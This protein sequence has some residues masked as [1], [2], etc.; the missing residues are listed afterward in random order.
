MLKTKMSL[1]LCLVLL[2]GGTTLAFG[3]GWQRRPGD[4]DH[5]RDDGYYRQ[6]S[7]DQ[8]KYYNRGLQDGQ[9][10]ARHNLAFRMRDHDWRRDQLQAYASG[11]RA[12]FGSYRRGDGD[13]DRDDRRGYGYGQPGV[14][15]YGQPGQYGGYAS[16][17]NIGYQDGLRYGASDRNT[18]HSFRPTNSSAYHD[19]KRGSKKSRVAESSGFPDVPMT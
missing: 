19:A 8:Q 10:D 4:G 7:R 15:G 14:Y 5:D 1:A 12:G 6:D 9:S 2:L 11:Y 3:Q 16:A 18:G 17:Y 13:H